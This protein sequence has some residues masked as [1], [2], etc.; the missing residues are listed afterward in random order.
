MWAYSKIVEFLKIASM[1]QK[2]FDGKNCICAITDI[3]TM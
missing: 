1:V 3:R 2:L